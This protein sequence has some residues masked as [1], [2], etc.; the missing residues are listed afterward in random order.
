M[1]LE[2]HPINSP[3]CLSVVVFPITYLP[4]QEE[5]AGI[6]YNL[7]IW[8]FT[9]LQLS[10]FPV[11]IKN[12]FNFLSLMTCWC[13]RYCDCIHQDVLLLITPTVSAPLAPE[14]HS[15]INMGFQSK[16]TW[17]VIKPL[18]PF[19]SFILIINVLISSTWKPLTALF[20]CCH[21]VLE[22]EFIACQ[23]QRKMLLIPVGA[24]SWV[25]KIN[26][27]RE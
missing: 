5:K 10:K 22:P 1:R 14:V 12:I 18:Y 3:H 17:W 25:T 15:L 13:W 20:V 21:Y 8:C 2:N 11:Y 23:N 26:D 9:C 24:K 6:T 16:V 27:Y 19:Y 4:I 7:I